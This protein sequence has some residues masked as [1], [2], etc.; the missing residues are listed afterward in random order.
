ME[1]R[2][3]NYRI[4]RGRRAVENVFGFLASRFR[5]LL[6]TIEQRSNFVRDIVFTW[7]L[8]V[9]QHAEDTPGRADSAPKPAD[10]IAAL[11]NELVVHVPIIDKLCVSKMMPSYPTCFLGCLLLFLFTECPGMLPAPPAEMLPTL[12]PET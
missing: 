11:Q 2:I 9:L 1:E 5:V 6:V 7:I 4:L 8:Y 12:R 3:A 10:D